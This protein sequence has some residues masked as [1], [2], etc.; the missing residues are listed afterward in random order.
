M[1][2]IRDEFYLSKLDEIIDYMASNTLVTAI[3]FLD[4]LDRKIEN[5]TNMPFKFRQSYYYK[6]EKIR[7]LIF[8]G[9][10]IPYLVD[11]QK[12]V[13]VIL[14]IFKYSYRKPLI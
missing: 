5:L 10:T 13:I 12:E 2:I 3:S 6:D 11:K 7:D 9:Y 14:D 1:Q 4:K 8:K